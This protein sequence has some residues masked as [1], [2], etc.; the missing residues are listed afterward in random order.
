MRNW[1]ATRLDPYRLLL[2][3]L[4][5]IYIV[6]FY[7]LATD[8]HTGMRT[9]KADLGQIDQA[10]W[11]SSRGRF[12]EQTDN[13]FV[14]TRL[15]DHVEPMLVFI[16]PI[17]W[18][19]ND[20]RALLLLQAVAVV[21]GAWIL[22]E[23]SLRQ[24]D[25]LLTPQERSQIWQ[26]EPLRNSTRPLA[27]SLT[28]AYLLTPQLQSALLTE[29][30]AAPLVVPLILW[31]FWAVDSGHW[32]QF[33]AAALLVA[34]VKEEMAL[35]AAGLGLWAV[36]RSK[37]E[38]RRSETTEAT[39][40]SFYD[41]RS[42]GLLAGTVVTTFSLLWFVVA[43]FVIV[44]AYAADVYG[45]A[46]S[47]YFQ[48]YGALG[49]SPLDI[50]RSFFTQPGV[51]WQIATEPARV[52]Y[53]IG[54]LMPFGFLS[55]LGPEI[56]LLSLPVLLA[57]LLS[58]YPAQ[59]Y[60]DFHYS[61][62]LVPYVASAAAYGLGRLWRWLARRTDGQSASFQ[63]MPA[64]DRGTMTV[65]ALLANSRTTLRPLVTVA[66]AGW[67]LC[68]AGWSYMHH[69]RGPLGARHDPPPITA[70][71]QRLDHF[72]AR[73]PDDAAV[74]ATAAV[75]PH[76]SHR[77]YIYQ[78]PLGLD[79]PVP[80][81]WAL[82]DV[83]TN[84]DMA[85]G[86]LKTTVDEM[87]AGDW[88]V[89]DAG[90][91]F[92]VLSTDST[93]KEIP[94]GFYSFAR[95]SGPP[96][97]SKTAES[98]AE[99]ADVPLSFVGV[100]IDDW[101]RWRQTK[102]SGQWHVGETFDATSDVPYLEVRTPTGDTVGSLIDILPPAL[103]W[104]PPERWQPGETIHITSLPLYLPK[105]WGLVI[106]TKAVDATGASNLAP[107]AIVGLEGRERLATALQRGRQ[108]RLTPAPSTQADLTP[109]VSEPDE[110]VGAVRA[111]F[112]VSETDTLEMHATLLDEAI[113]PGA[114]VDVLLSWQGMEW[115]ANLSAF[116][117]LRRDGENV[118]QA[119]GKPR[120]FV[121]PPLESLKVAN[122]PALV[123]WRQLT[124]P[125]NQ[126][127]PSVD[128][129]KW[130]LVVGLYDPNNGERVDAVDSQGHP[131]GQEVTIGTLR[132]ESAPVPDQACALIP[133]TCASQTS[134]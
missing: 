125:V 19:W 124:V 34:S 68:W 37:I 81:Q 15:T 96:V 108:D 98:T 52:D 74:T 69:G 60:G 23:L 109:L 14:A 16:S 63:Q 115:P 46:E 126:P 85:P 67:I 132:W 28:I 44:P 78:F 10:V 50:F 47:G 133:A 99:P 26:L 103:V 95:A 73:I 105:T 1:I 41:L 59:Y 94:E 97:G 82:L 35:L 107:G 114:T 36:L 90:D 61:A 87:L 29:F 71:H 20:V 62:P 30:H 18:L 111:L 6:I 127:A 66:L 55:L 7:G 88:G 27:L 48:R 8:I 113:W 64:A 2:S 33:T 86:D 117:H 70:H 121:H 92:L 58:A 31:A 119:D 123:D 116:V 112:A 83:T 12:L 130:N 102:L 43:T 39:R 134:R 45:V 106:D 4:M 25:K 17:F 118:G 56:L 79:A 21:I 104:Y 93:Q 77:Q 80:A 3:L 131:V 24:F 75:H 72:L 51:V 54:L 65:A 13:G 49:D 38:D 122:K 129:G 101:P 9:H 22:Y 40:S 84:T 76:L 5:T 32:G 57:N 42:S 89:V 120:Y 91:G 128:D 53:L 11:N 100:E 110:D